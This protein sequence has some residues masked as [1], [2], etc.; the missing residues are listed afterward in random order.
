MVVGKRETRRLVP[1]EH[2]LLNNIIIVEVGGRINHVM[3]GESVY[4]IVNNGDWDIR[5]E[6]PIH[7]H[8]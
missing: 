5:A 8:G 3:Y 7:H 1:K 4:A 2:A 6:H